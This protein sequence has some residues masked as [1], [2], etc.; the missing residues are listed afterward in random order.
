MVWR[1]QYCLQLILDQ[2]AS[3]SKIGFFGPGDYPAIGTAGWIIDFLNPNDVFSPD[4]PHACSL[5]PDGFKFKPSVKQNDFYV[6]RFRDVDGLHAI[7]NNT[8]KVM[9]G[10]YGYLPDPWVGADLKQFITW[11][12]GKS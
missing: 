5:A 9:K 2:K 3:G 4:K 12:Y 8:D 6:P 7:M 10:L 1:Y 11:Y